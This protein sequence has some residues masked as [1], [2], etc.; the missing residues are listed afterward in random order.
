MA[1]HLGRDDDA[2]VAR[3][4]FG[5]ADRVARRTRPHR[6]FWVFDVAYLGGVPVKASVNI[7]IA[8]SRFYKELT[9]TLPA[10]SAAMFARFMQIEDDHIAL[11]Q[12]ELDYLSHTGYW[13]GTKEFD[14][15]DY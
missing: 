1:F 15:E 3:Q 14:M 4:R 12:A 10:E 2:Y 6:T 7:E 8:T 11:V 13:F 5:R 9:D